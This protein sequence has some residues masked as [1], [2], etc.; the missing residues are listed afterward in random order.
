MYKLG[1]LTTILGVF[2]LFQWLGTMQP[3]VTVQPRP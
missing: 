2:I 1:A 3:R